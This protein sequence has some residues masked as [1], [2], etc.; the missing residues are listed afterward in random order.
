VFRI[1]EQGIITVGRIMAH[2]SEWVNRTVNVRGNL[3]KSTEFE[4]FLFHSSWVYRLSSDGGSII[5]NA[6]AN[7]YIDYSFETNNAVSV[8]VYGVVE[9]LSTTSGTNSSVTTN[10]YYITANRIVIVLSHFFHRSSCLIK[11]KKKR[12]KTRENLDNEVCAMHK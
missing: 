1:K 12:G 9:K 5:V 10:I 11:P 2:P 6:S 4:A 3:S 7:P 8:V